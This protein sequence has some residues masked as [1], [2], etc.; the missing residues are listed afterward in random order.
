[1]TEKLHSGT[2]NIDIS[3]HTCMHAHTHTQLILKKLYKTM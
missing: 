2:V 3:K 1:M